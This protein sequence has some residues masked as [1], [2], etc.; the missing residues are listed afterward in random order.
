MFN[1]TSVLQRQLKLRDRDGS[2]ITAEAEAVFTKL[3]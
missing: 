1:R 2:G 3:N